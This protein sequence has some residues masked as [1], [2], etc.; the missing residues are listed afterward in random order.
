MVEK[1]GHIVKVTAQGKEGL[2]MILNEDFDRVIC[3]LMLQDITGFDIIE[4]SKRVFSLDEIKQRFVIMTAY[5]SDAILAK[6]KNYQCKIFHKP[7]KD[8]EETLNSILE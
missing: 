2:A 3:D 8:V 7:F 1:R 6:A 4:E 5:T